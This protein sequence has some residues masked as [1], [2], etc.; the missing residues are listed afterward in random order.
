MSPGETGPKQLPINWRNR[1]EGIPSQI[2][3]INANIF[4]CSS[5]SFMHY[6]LPTTYTSSLGLSISKWNES[7]PS[8]RNENIYVACSLT[9]YCTAIFWLHRWHSKI[10]RPWTYF[11]RNR[12]YMCLKTIHP[13]LQC[14]WYG[15]QPGCFFGRPITGIDSPKAPVT[16]S[17]LISFT[18][19][20]H[21]KESNLP[22][23]SNR[24]IRSL[25]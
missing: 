18:L 22:G 1:K 4:S 13:H 12:L 7:R 19:H 5:V 16:W 2:F 10:L 3:L 23:Q 20:R 8:Y 25:D 21:P 9:S 17:L 15:P 11:G 14:R 24:S 6:S